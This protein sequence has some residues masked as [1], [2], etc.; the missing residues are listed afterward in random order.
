MFGKLFKREKQ[1]DAVQAPSGGEKGERPREV[2]AAVGR[3]LVVKFHEDP[4]W[5]W[6]LKQVQQRSVQGEHVRDLRVYD[7]TMAAGRGVAVRNYKSLD[8]HPELILY[9]GWL[10]VRNNEVQLV[11][12]G[13]AQQKAS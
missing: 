2:N 4:D 13:G 7:P 5:V 6:K 1:G 3:D 11:G 10:N 9:H 12:G 8:E